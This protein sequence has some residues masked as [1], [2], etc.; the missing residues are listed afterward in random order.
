ME[1]GKKERRGWRKRGGDGGW[2]ERWVGVVEGYVEGRRSGGEGGGDVGEDWD[3]D[4]GSGRRK[5]IGEVGECRWSGGVRSGWVGFGMKGKHEVFRGERN[6]LYIGS[7]LVVV[8]ARRL[9]QIEGS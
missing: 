8:L 7:E 6:E 2:V 5:G 4:R 3:G 9:S 1:R